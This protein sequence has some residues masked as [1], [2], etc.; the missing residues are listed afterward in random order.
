[1]LMHQGP[2]NLFTGVADCAP[3]FEI[4]DYP[5]LFPIHDGSHRNLEVQRNLTLRHERAGGGVRHCPRFV[6]ACHIAKSYHWFFFWNQLASINA[7]LRRPVPIFAEKRRLNFFDKVDDPSWINRL[8]WRKA[9]RSILGI[10]G[11]ADTT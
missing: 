11:S 5:P 2:V 4:G 6:V 3:Y 9:C 10:S 8:T 7:D 1:M